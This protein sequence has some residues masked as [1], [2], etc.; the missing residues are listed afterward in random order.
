[1]EEARNG[2]ITAV[3]LG[4]AGVLLQYNGVKLLIDGIYYDRSGFFS[5]VPSFILKSLLQGQ[6]C[7]RD[8]DYFLFSHDHSDH[9]DSRR[10]AL[11][12][13]HQAP[14]LVILPAE[15]SADAAYLLTHLKRNQI[16]YAA[17]SNRRPGGQDNQG[18]SNGCVDRGGQGGSDGSNG[19]GDQGGGNDCRGQVFSLEKGIFVTAIPTTHMGSQYADISHFSFLVTMGKKHILFLADAGCDESCLKRLEQE[20]IHSV[21]VTPL[22]F[23]SKTG[24]DVLRRILRPKRVII[25]HLPFEGQDPNG[26]RKMAGWDRERDQSADWTVELFHRAGQSLLL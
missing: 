3:L 23:H 7:F 8:I 10:I 20:P 5:N 14:K 15:G 13:A 9:F 19:S 1:M 26:Y 12:L 2:E 18:G 22:F 4:N 25:Y 17:L 21:F 11:G 6:G 16:P 24:R